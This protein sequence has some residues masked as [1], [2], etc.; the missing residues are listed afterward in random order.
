M[1]QRMTERLLKFGGVKMAFLRRCNSGDHY[2][3]SRKPGPLS[4]K[5]KTY[6]RESF[7]VKSCGE[8][9]STGGWFSVGRIRVTCPI[10]FVGHRIRLKVEVLE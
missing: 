7:L 5:I 10:V 1:I 6:F 3:C 4:K 2:L 9:Y 8:D